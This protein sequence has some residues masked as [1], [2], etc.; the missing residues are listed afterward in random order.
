VPTISDKYKYAVSSHTSDDLTSEV[1]FLTM[2][3]FHD[4][5]A[6]SLSLAWS[7]RKLLCNI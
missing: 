4:N 1:S 2:D 6:I 3:V 7:S 5:V